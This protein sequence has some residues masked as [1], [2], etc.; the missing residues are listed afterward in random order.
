MVYSAVLG[1]VA[2]WHASSL[3]CNSDQQAARQLFREIDTEKQ[4][5]AARASI[6][7]GIDRK[8]VKNNLEVGATCDQWMRASQFETTLRRDRSRRFEQD[9]HIYGISAVSRL[10]NKG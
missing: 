6:T 7:A 9:E 8:W 5:N 10:E 4:A 3:A 2:R 1:T